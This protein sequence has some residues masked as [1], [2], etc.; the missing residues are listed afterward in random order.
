M[1]LI[2]KIVIYNKYSCYLLLFLTFTLDACNH[3]Q[4]YRDAYIVSNNNKYFIK[5]RGKRNLMAHDPISLL[6]NSTY[7]DSVLIPVPYIKN[8]KISGHEMVFD[9]GYN[10]YTYD[11]YV[12]INGSSLKINLYSFDTVDN[13]RKPNYFGWNGDYLLHGNGNIPK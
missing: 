4:N 13:K 11:G 10:K 1:H 3:A 12:L 2:K 9:D 6:K 7:E 5:L 8:K